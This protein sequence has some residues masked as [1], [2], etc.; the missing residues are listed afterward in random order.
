MLQE[1]METLRRVSQNVKMR[2]R[3]PNPGV[4]RKILPKIAQIGGFQAYLRGFEYFG[5]YFTKNSRIWG[6]Q[7]HFYAL[8]YP[9]KCFHTFLKHVRVTSCKK[10]GLRGV[11]K[12]HFFK[13]NSGPY[14]TEKWPKMGGVRI[15]TSFAMNIFDKSF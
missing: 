8:G 3:P 10:S 4:F 9:P 12:R 6:S 13:K 11:S 1:S 7:T 5:Q 15:F 14:C 2:L